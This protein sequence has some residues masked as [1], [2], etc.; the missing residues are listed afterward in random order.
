MKNER[1]PHAQDAE[2][3][4]EKPATGAKPASKQRRYVGG[5][6]YEGDVFKPDKK[7]G[8]FDVVD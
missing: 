7:P 2:K 3:V 5:G 6:Y 1:D 4:Q 8:A